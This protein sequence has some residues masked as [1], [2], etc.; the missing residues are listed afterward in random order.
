MQMSSEQRDALKREI[1]RQHPE[2]AERFAVLHFYLH[3][4]SVDRHRSGIVPHIRPS[5][6]GKSGTA[7]EALGS[8]HAHLG[9]R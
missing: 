6:Q 2:P 7:D 9:A 3:S 4:I 8:L 5:W 1:L